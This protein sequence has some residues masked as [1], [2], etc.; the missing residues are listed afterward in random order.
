VF[1]LHAGFVAFLSCLVGVLPLPLQQLG[2]F[3]CIEAGTHAI[4]QFA[5]AVGETIT[6]DD[7]EHCD[8]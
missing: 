8:R 2:L 3:Q 1:D 4:I 5:L 6:V 7:G